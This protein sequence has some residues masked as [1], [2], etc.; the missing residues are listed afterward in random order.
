MRSSP[1]GETKIADTKKKKSSSS[2]GSQ[3]YRKMQ[4]R[5][6]YKGNLENYP[7][8]IQENRSNLSTFEKIFS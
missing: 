5:K 2:I 6:P 8:G 1:S 3:I 7:Q 4:D